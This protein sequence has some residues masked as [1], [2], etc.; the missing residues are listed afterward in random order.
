[1]VWTG[2]DLFEKAYYENNARFI[3]TASSEA[4]LDNYVLVI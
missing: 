1:L 3:A 2:I 4:D